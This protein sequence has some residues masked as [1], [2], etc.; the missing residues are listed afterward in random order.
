[1]KPRRD[2]SETSAAA[3]RERLISLLAVAALRACSTS[4][5]VNS[6]PERVGEGTHPKNAQ[7]LGPVSPS[8]K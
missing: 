4:T 3:R 2:E 7:E 8:Q 1:M 5:V 6:M